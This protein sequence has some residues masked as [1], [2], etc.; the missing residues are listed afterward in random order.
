LA[1]LDNFCH[2]IVS[3]ANKT[4]GLQSC[5]PTSLKHGGETRPWRSLSGMFSSVDASREALVRE[6][7]PR[8][9]EHLIA[10]IDVDLLKD[11]VEFL[12][13]FPP[14]FDIL[15]YANVPTLQN[16]LP[17]YYT[18]YQAWQPDSNDTE[19]LLLLKR[20]FLQIL[21]AKYWTSLTMLHF[22]ASYLDPSLK[23][24]RFVTDLNDRDGFFRQVRE[25]IISLVKEPYVGDVPQVSAAD[26]LTNKSDTSIM[27][28]LP[29]A[30]KMKVS[31]FDWF[32]SPNQDGVST[33]NTP[34]SVAVEPLKD[35]VLKEIRKYETEPSPGVTGFDPLCWWG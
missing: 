18:L 14:L 15:E 1:D 28:D 13:V 16:A 6:L 11:I 2:D 8:K 9:K 4:S 12:S 3:Y 32:Q 26:I 21:D 35:R 23:H 5:L 20:H 25:A 19:S 7:K 10:R 22:T 33:A 24:F 30:K 31:P 34:A 17:V 27:T 29:P